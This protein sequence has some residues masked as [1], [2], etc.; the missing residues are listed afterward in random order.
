MFATI[1]RMSAKK[2][3]KIFTGKEL[4]Y[5]AFPHGL[6]A[7]LWDDVN[8]A[9]QDI[10]LVKKTKP[11]G[12]LFLP[13][14]A[15]QIPWTSYVNLLDKALTRCSQRGTFEY[16]K[17]IKDRFFEEMTWRDYVGAPADIVDE[18]DIIMS[19]V[20]FLCPALD[21]YLKD[22]VKAC[23]MALRE[24]SLNKFLVCWPRRFRESLAVELHSDLEHLELYSRK[25]FTQ[26]SRSKSIICAPFTHF[27]H[28]H[29][30]CVSRNARARARI[31]SLIC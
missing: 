17:D 29:A 26:Y 1:I 23:P 20:P 10:F 4:Y 25:R 3:W 28:L 16:T 15:L 18:I 31:C 2:I 27:H 6:D 8:R 30:A 11:N 14:Q 7:M 22:I 21:V 19:H 5:G 9:F 13:S 24:V 12:L